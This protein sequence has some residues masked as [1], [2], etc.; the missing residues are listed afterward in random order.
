MYLLA[1]VAA[2]YLLYRASFGIATV[3]VDISHSMAS[4]GFAAGAL[5]LVVLAAMLLR[6]RVVVNPQRVH[7]LAMLK[8]N[9]NAGVLEVMGA[10]LTGA[11]VWVV[12]RVCGSRWWVKS[13]EPYTHAGGWSRHAPPYQPH[14]SHR[15]PLITHCQPLMTHTLCVA[16]AA[17]CV[18]RW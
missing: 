18:A 4:Y 16:Q 12:G 6:A 1:A 8:L 17:R 15:Q 14:T 9:S 13:D 11:G 3:F 2:V 10:P 5:A 7:Q